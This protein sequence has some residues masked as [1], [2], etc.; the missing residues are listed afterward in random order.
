MRPIRLS[1]LS[2]LFLLAVLSLASCGGTRAGEDSALQSDPAATAA[3]ADETAASTVATTAAAETATTI[4]PLAESVGL[5]FVSNGD[6]TCSVSGIGACTDADVV[7]PTK[8][9]AGDPVTGIKDRAFPAAKTI[10][11]VVIPEGVKNVGR[12]AFYGCESLTAVTIPDSVTNIGEAAFRGCT[13]LKSV[14]LGNGIAGIA[15]NLFFHCTSLS[16][17]ALPAGVTSIGNAAFSGCTALSSVT[18]PEGLKRIGDSV[19]SGCTALSSVTI[20]EGVESVGRSAFSGCTA[21]PSM[22]VPDSVTSIG[23]GAFSGCSSLTAITLPFV[24]ATAGLTE[25]DEGQYPFGYVFGKTGYAGGTARE[26]IYRKDAENWTKETYYVP[27]SLRSVTIT[28]GQL[29][30][31]AFY[32]CRDLTSITVPGDLTKVEANTFALC[33]S[34]SSLRLPQSVTSIGDVAFTGC[35]ALTSFTIPKNVSS[36]GLGVFSSCPALENLTVADGNEYYSVAGNCL[37]EVSSGRLLSGCSSSVIPTDGSVTTVEGY[38]FSAN[39]KAQ[40]YSIVIPE[41]VTGIGDYAFYYCAYLSSITI[42]ASL[43][44][45]GEGAFAYCT[46]LNEIR[47]Q[48]TQAEWNA[49]EKG[50]GYNDNTGNYAVRCTDGTLNK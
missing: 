24:G 4:E 14:T 15:E 44:K 43:K 33:I 20:P 40:P 34:L 5:S 32:E 18:I 35:A 49:I 36:I 21:L 16:A 31:G 17:I 37:I 19:F 7:I 26:Q 48:G 25:R 6:G 30:A 10:K 42:P 9:P 39:M 45:I 8:S 50:A 46:L 27:S 28:G 38:S 1:V 23:E 41:G 29:P 13:E 2:L 47:F 3:T 11:S 22:T 12:F